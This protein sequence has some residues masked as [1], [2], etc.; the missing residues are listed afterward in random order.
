MTAAHCLSRLL[1]DRA[2]CGVLDI[3]FAV[4]QLAVCAS[5]LAALLYVLRKNRNR[6]G[7]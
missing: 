2:Q 1:C 5:I 6:D 3:V 4:T 7:G